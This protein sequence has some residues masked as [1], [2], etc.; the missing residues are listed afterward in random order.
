LQPSELCLFPCFPT[1]F[2][3]FPL[4]STSKIDTQNKSNADNA[5]LQNTAAA[6]CRPALYAQNIQKKGYGE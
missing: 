4:F 3:K 2:R 1:F 6:R 5:P